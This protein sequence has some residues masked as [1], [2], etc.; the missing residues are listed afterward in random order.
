MSI[1][2][3]I[4]LRIQRRYRLYWNTLRMSPHTASRCKY[5]HRTRDAPLE[6]WHCCPLWQRQLTNKLNAREFAAMHSVA[7]PELYWSGRPTEDLPFDDLPEAYVLRPTAG[8][9]S[10]GVY[11]MNGDVDL[12]S[13]RTLA[14]DDLRRELREWFRTR[15]RRELI[16]AEEFLRTPDGC[17][18]SPVEYKVYVFGDV[19]GLIT[20]VQRGREG[21]SWSCYRE[22]WSRF[23]WPIFK[24]R[25]SDSA[26][27][28]P[29][30]LD[31]ICSVA[32]RLGRSFGSFVRVD[33]YETNRG[34][35]FGEF[36][37][38]PNLGRAFSGDGDRYLGQ[39]W[40]EN[41]Q[42]AV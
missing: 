13:G 20:A 4:S 8:T 6:S 10:E 24:G 38:T 29:E 16:L 27:P 42:Q 41:W 21:R 7:V 28:R 30:S 5:K 25:A 26:I 3:L 31:E 18:A 40:E 37:A 36:C 32:R 22:D 11:L 1:P 9:R 14:S 17:V 34:V 12:L 19:I 35:V 2:P 39:L 33:L 15:S 23:D